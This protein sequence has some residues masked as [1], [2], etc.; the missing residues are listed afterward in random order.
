MQLYKLSLKTHS[1]TLLLTL[2]F[3]PHI[4]ANCWSYASQKFGI[5]KNLLI[6]IA[7]VESEMNPGALNRNNNGSYDIGLMQINSFHM[8]KL[9]KLGLTEEH[10]KRDPCVSILVGASILADMM[11]IYGYSWEAV[12]AYNAGTSK[13]RHEVRMR[14]ARKVWERYRR[15]V[16]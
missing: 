14:Y 1:I 11:K 7:Q 15:N 5:D 4:Q 8:P 2:W 12:G 10:L 9:R 16:R 13:T 6:A 3:S